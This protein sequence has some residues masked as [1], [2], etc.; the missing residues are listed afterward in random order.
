MKSQPL[1]G[2]RHRTS[3]G[4][5]Q[6]TAWACLPDETNFADDNYNNHA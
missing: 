6:N 4:R 3:T 5:N 1:P 2:T